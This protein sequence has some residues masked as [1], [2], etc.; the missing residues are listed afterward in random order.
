[1]K[2]KPDSTAL[3]PP[4]VS[5]LYPPRSTIDLVADELPGAIEARI[6]SGDPVQAGVHPAWLLKLDPDMLAAL[7]RDP[8]AGRILRRSIAP[9]EVLVE[10]SDRAELSGLLAGWGIPLSWG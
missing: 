8:D 7:Q 1:M 2:A 9:G 3:E 6:R 5:A 10:E 4:Q